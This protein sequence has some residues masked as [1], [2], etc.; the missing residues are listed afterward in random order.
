MDDLTLAAQRLTGQ[1]MFKLLER[2][3]IMEKD[4]KNFIHFEIGDPDFDTALS[5]KNA[6]IKALD[7]NFTHYTSSSGI[8]DLKKA[9][10]TFLFRTGS[11]FMPDLNQIVVA[12]GCNPLIYC[13]I[14]WRDK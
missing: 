5:I 4:G 7:D 12:P 3:N 1:P 9:I 8:E 11:G 2:I 6:C 10:S 14:K 13:I